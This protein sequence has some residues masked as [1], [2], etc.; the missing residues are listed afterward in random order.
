LPFCNKG[1]GEEGG[2]KAKKIKE[3]VERGKQRRETE[4]KN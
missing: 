1:K 4:R 3:K 2:K